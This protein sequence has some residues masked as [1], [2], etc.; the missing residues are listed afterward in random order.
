VFQLDVSDLQILAGLLNPTTGALTVLSRNFADYRNRGVEA[1]LQ[2]VPVDG[3]NIYTN[4][5]YQ[6]DKYL[7]PGNAP[8]TD[9][10][11][12]Q[13]V[14][15]QLAS[16]RGALAAGKVPGGPNTPATQPSITACAAGIV[17]A[18][19]TIATPVRTPKWSISMGAS[20]EA[21]LGGGYTLVPSV[22]GAFHS[23]QEVAIA[24]LS[25]YNGPVAGV[26]QPVTGPF[27]ANPF[28]NGDFI[29]GS[30]SEAVW[31]FNAGLALNAPDKAWTLSVD[32]TNCLNE[33]FVQ[34]ALSNYSYLNRPMEWTV[35]AKYRF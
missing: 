11:G 27:P 13:S 14:A 17:T 34:S 4:F 12:I 19:G 1:E 16:C 7:V 30:Q 15:A 22:N 35:R 23:R 21:Q 26:N 10:Y 29:T 20:Y 31:L 28:G 32:C 25:I 8:A 18:Q 6:N 2:F 9:V 3:L 5:G 24:N 33:S